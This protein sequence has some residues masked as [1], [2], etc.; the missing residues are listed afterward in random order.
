M[1]ELEELKKRVEQLNLTTS[2]TKRSTIENGKKIEKVQTTIEGMHKEWVVV[3]SKL[4]GDEGYF[5]QTNKNAEDI[6][7]IHDDIDLIDIKLGKQD[8]KLIKIIVFAVTAGL[9]LGWL[10][11]QYRYEAKKNLTSSLYIKQRDWTGLKKELN[12]RDYR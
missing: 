4:T 3:V 10:M 7:L 1:S 6:D 5:K 11:S 12:D 9:I 8:I 2:H